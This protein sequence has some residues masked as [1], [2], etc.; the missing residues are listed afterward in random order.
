MCRNFFAYILEDRLRNALTLYLS[1]VCKVLD[2][3]ATSI[4]YWYITEEMI[5]WGQCAHSRSNSIVLQVQGNLH[6]SSREA[7]EICQSRG[8]R[9][10]GSLTLIIGPVM[11]FTR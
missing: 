3:N 5:L 2:L 8:I 11:C 10:L 6:L 7:Q 1:T 9:N 4:E